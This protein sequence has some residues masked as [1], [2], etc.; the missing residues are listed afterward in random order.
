MK[1][2]AVEQRQAE[3]RRLATLMFLN[4]EPDRLL[5][6]YLM[7]ITLEAYGIKKN[8]DDLTADYEYLRKVGLVTFEHIAH[9]PALKLTDM[10]AEV[11]KGTRKVEGVQAP[12]LDG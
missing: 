7:Q 2:T 12:P 6:Y 10:G 11:I 1:N 8:S 3:H 9:L 4:E 5:S